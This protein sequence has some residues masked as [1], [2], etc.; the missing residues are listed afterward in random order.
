MG[1]NAAG[2][3]G[4]PFETLSTCLALIEIV[5]SCNL[6]CPTC[7]A[8][9][10][11]GVGGRV[12]AVPIGDLQRR[13]E[14]VIS[15]KGR[16]EILQLSGGEPTLHP[17]FFELLEWA[18]GHP[19]IDY[20]LVNTN[21]VKLAG[22]IE[23]GERLAVAAG[24]RKLQLYLQ[25]DGVQSAGQVA[26]RGADFREVRLWAIQKAAAMDLPVTLAMTVTRENLAHVWEAI[27]FGLSEPMI[28]G[29]T[30]QPVFESG[31]VGSRAT[32]SGITGEENKE[33]AGRLNTADV[34]LAVVGQSGGQLCF[35]DFTP[36]PCGDPNCATV[37]YLLRIGGKVHSVSEFLNFS[38][39]Q[40]FLKDKVRYTLED[41]ARCGCETEPLG[42]VLKQLELKSEMAFR[43][44]VKPFMDA[45]TWDED[46]IDRCCTHV[47]RPDGKL[48]SFC[49]YYSGFPDT[50]L[51]P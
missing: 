24:R 21:G 35:E 47:I 25:F 34:L 49:R 30:F 11:L 51:E 15:R 29:I 50:V 13:I 42:E 19:N 20:V 17:Q 7:Y 10:P 39:L 31:R 38:E 5:H 44:L 41:L 4:S 8:D 33:G 3:A 27:A 28:H 40:G 36:L 14:G 6:S 12:D 22:D 37:G 23:F 9:S 43:I 18:Q 46:R 32:E 48:D 16:L 26:L 2:R 45:W 1:R